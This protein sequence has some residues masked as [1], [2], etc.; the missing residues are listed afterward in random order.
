MVK[1]VFNNNEDTIEIENMVLKYMFLVILE[2]NPARG[3]Q[4]GHPWCWSQARINGECWRQEGHPAVKTPRQ[5]VHDAD[6]NEPRPC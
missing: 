2:E 1:E 3:V 6:P 5:S 4:P